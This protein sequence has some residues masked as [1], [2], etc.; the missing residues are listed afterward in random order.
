M[1]SQDTAFEESLACATI[2][3]LSNILEP[4]LWI[5]NC[6]RENECFV[7]TFALMNKKVAH[8]VYTWAHTHLPS[9]TRGGA[10]GYQFLFDLADICTPFK[11]KLFAYTKENLLDLMADPYYSGVFFV[12]D[13]LQK[14]KQMYELF[15]AYLKNNISAMLKTENGRDALKLMALYGDTY[16]IFKQAITCCTMTNLPVMT[17]TAEGQDFL[18]WLAQ[19]SDYHKT[20]VINYAT[21]NVETLVETENGQAFITKIKNT[22]GI[23]VNPV[24]TKIMRVIRKIAWGSSSQE[25]GK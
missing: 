5:E 4:K 9:L 11:E 7:L 15:V 12:K 3:H 21:T 6:K 17:A 16:D 14:N 8:A 24:T 25:S 20:I 10:G 18:C 2:T 1:A 19:S 23:N 13:L 22:L